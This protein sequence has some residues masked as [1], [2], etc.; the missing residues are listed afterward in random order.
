V[1]IDHIIV[2]VTDLGEAGLHFRERHG[3][4]SYDG[5]RHPAWGTANRI[6]PL[7]AAYLEL[8]AVVDEETAGTTAFGRRVVS[9]ATPA[10]SPLG[11]AVRPRDLTATAARLGLDAQEGSRSTPT[12]DVVRWRSAGLE[13]AVRDP[14]LPFF[15]EWESTFPGSAVE[16]NP[17][18][19]VRIELA[20]NER[21]LT[22]WLGGHALPIEVHPGDSGP[23][24]IVLT[25]PRGEVVL[26]SDGRG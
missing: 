26:P 1:T 13:E 8:I 3:L 7:G 24:A 5:G 12:G 17:H 19:I 22:E 25:G 10:G 2:A 6:V 4:A 20:G 11:W 9:G 14:A 15:V 16:P 18:S 23:L 21:R